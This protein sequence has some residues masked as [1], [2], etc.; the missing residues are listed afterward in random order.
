LRTFNNSSNVSPILHG[1]APFQNSRLRLKAANPS[2]FDR[3]EITIYSH[4]KELL[5]IGRW[6][7]TSFNENVTWV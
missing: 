2:L 3:D 5:Y 1:F 7:T 6:R 4:K